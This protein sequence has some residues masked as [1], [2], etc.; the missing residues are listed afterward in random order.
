MKTKFALAAAAL[1]GSAVAAVAG[2]LEPVI[3]EA[4]VVVEPA[5]MGSGLGYLIPIL[6][7]A[8]LIFAASNKTHNGR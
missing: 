1:V 8:A 7:V 4:P 2:G 6:I 5:P 3:I